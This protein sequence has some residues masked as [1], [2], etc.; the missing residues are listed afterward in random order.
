MRNVQSLL[1]KNM[2]EENKTRLFGESALIEKVAITEI[3]K[4]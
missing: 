1:E 2:T 4:G 3:Q